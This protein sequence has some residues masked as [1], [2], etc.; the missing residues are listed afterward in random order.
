MIER[1][2]PWVP[3][4]VALGILGLAV[5]YLLPVFI[6]FALA[7][8][9]AYVVNP[10][11]AAAEVRGLRRQ[12]VVIVAYL[13][14]ALALALLAGKL[15]PLIL[16]EVASLQSELPSYAAR[17]RLN[18]IE[19]QRRASDRMPFATAYISRLDP[20]AALAPLIERAEGLPA[21]LLSAFPL[22]SLLFLIPFISFFLLMDGPVSIERLIQRCPSRYVEQALHLVS[23]VDHSLGAYLRGLIIVACTLATASFVGLTL[24]G[25]NQALW[26]SLLSGVSSFVPYLGAIV[27]M[28]VGGLAAGFQFG[29]ITAGLKVVALFLL[30]RFG[31]EMI[32]QPF[33]AK[34]SVHLHPLLFLFTFMAGGELF[35]FIGLLF[36]VP[37]AC[38]VKALVDVAWSWYS[39]E[40]RLIPS[41]DAD[42]SVVPYT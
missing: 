7:C 30:I 5:H 4:F 37:V 34:Q 11:A 13:L 38:V 10:L 21:Y 32:M 35:G 40:A 41:E 26:I 33:I 24:L 29:T 2:F 8:A 19:L 25:V 39:S 23:E 20:G 12:A 36:A 14:T 9:V 22:L 18:F 3:T 1:R 6:P 17:L 15:V 27:G 42:S 28:V 31:D 16:R